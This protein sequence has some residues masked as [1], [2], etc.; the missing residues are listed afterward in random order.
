MRP[1][2]FRRF[3][4]CAFREFRNAYEQ[5]LRE[6]CFTR[7]RVATLVPISFY[8]LFLQLFNGRCHVLVP[9]RIIDG[10]SFEPGF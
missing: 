5:V 2:E 4:V 3:R 1:R 6:G 9:A 8:P 7:S 10:W